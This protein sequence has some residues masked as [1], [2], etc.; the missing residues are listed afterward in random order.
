MT[1][2]QIKRLHSTLLLLNEINKNFEDR[3]ATSIEGTLG[4]MIIE[5]LIPRKIS[6]IPFKT[7]IKLRED[8]N[9]LRIGFHNAVHKISE[10]FNLNEII[11]KKTA[12]EKL[13]DCYRG[14]EEAYKKFN[15]H[16]LKTL[17]FIKNWRVQTFGISLCIFGTY[18]SGGPPASLY[19]SLSGAN[20]SLLGAIFSK[21]KK[22]DEE[23]SYSYIQKIK[24]RLEAIECINGLKPFLKGVRL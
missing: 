17:R 10:E 6:D 15:S 7:A 8:Y 24:Q 20:I 19:I 12:E 23:K 2:S 22:S 16:R 3:S 9:D 4:S 1:Y 13:R 11:D 14:Y 18:L 21:P 5:S